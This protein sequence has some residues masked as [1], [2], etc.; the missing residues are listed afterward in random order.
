[1]NNFTTV[2]V[3][4]TQTLSTNVELQQQSLSDLDKLLERNLVYF[5]NTLLVLYVIIF[6][7]GLTGNSIVLFVLTSSL[8]LSRDAQSL[9]GNNSKLV[10]TQNNLNTVDNLDA[11]YINFSTNRRRFFKE[12]L[13]VT[14][15][16][17]LNLAISDFIYLFLIPFLLL[18]MISGQWLFGLLFCKLY[19][20][21]VYTCQCSSI[22]ILI[23]LTIDRFLSVKYPHK[24]ASFRT[25]EKARLIIAINWILSILFSLPITLF[26]KIQNSTC[27]IIWPETWNFSIKNGLT[28]FL[29]NF[30]LPLHA[31]TAYTFLLNYLIPV[32]I[33]IILYSD[34]LIRLNKK[35]RLNMSK[36]KKKS[37]RKIA[38]MVL[39]IIVCYIISWTPYWS[40]QVF[41]YFYQQ[42]LKRNNSYILIISSHF[43]QVVAY[44]SSTLNPF[45]Y[46]YMSEVFQKEL[47][48]VLNN[49]CGCCFASSTDHAQKRQTIKAKRDPEVEQADDK[50][51]ER[52]ENDLSNN[53]ALDLNRIVDC[54]TRAKE[55]LKNMND[56]VE[57]ESPINSLKSTFNKNKLVYKASTS[58][59][60]F[61]FK[62]HSI[63]LKNLF[64]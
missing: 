24:V 48:I 26:T 21:L 61:E 22:F 1:M 46:S 31:F 3:N 33:I 29:D 23:I 47:K 62:I 39:M 35:T 6:L 5:E 7:I 64:K 25:H 44:L 59:I 38:I 36:Q 9:A 43:A 57:N 2:S 20:S 13:S 17:V 30:L 42:I 55:E 49:F 40:I 34:I 4:F 37:H 52:Q 56:T 51:F 11:I 16:Y 53:N 63:D 54:E 58:K 10:R 50:Q 8:C 41:N 32:S 12:K 15:F 45:I 19:F 27:S 14:N 60:A 28:E 18:T